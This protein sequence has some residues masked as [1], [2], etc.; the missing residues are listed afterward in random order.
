[1]AL[2]PAAAV[3]LVDLDEI[4]SLNPNLGADSGR[5]SIKALNLHLQPVVSGSGL[6]EHVAEDRGMLAGV[7]DDDVTHVAVVIEV[8]EGGAAAGGFASVRRPNCRTP[9]RSVPSPCSGEG[10]GEH[11][12]T[13]WARLRGCCPR[14]AH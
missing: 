3:D 4:A 7:G 2:K 9:P 8:V 14:C 1:M 11:D 5:G 12:R 10:W 6:D 13:R